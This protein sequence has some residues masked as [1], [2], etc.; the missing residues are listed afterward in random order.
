MKSFSGNK[1]V[2]VVVVVN[3]PDHNNIST[4]DMALCQTPSV[5]IILFMV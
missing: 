2:V 4:P 3:C 5:I 1:V